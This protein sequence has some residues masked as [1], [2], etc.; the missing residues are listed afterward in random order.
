VGLFRRRT[1]P[2]SPPPPEPPAST[3]WKELPVV[4]RLTGDLEPTVDTR[5]DR[6]LATWQSPAVTRLLDHGVRPDGPSGTVVR[7]AVRPAP[8]VFVPSED[9][10]APARSSTAA[11][12]PA[13]VVSLPGS[14]PQDG[15]E[16]AISPDSKEGMPAIDVER[17]RPVGL[18]A[19][20]DWPTNPSPHALQ[21]AEVIP[22]TV[23]AP[24][25][26][27]LPI[28]GG[29]ASARPVEP[30]AAPAATPGEAE[31]TTEV[32]SE[33]DDAVTTPPS[34]PSPEPFTVQATRPDDAAAPAVS[35]LTS[36]PTPPARLVGLGAPIQ[37][38][39]P[40]PTTPPA[41]T[42]TPPPTT[43]PPPQ[44]TDVTVFHPMGGFPSL[45]PVVTG[46]PAAAPASTSPAAPTTPTAAGLAGPTEPG[47]TARPVQRVS[48]PAATEPTVGLVAAMP[49]IARFPSG[50]GTPVTAG[51]Q[52]GA[53]AVAA[54]SAE[55][56][57]MERARAIPG[58]VR[59]APAAVTPS[60][61]VLAA[62]GLSRTNSV[63]V[64]WTDPGEVAVAA[65]VAQRQLDG[66]VVFRAASADQPDEASVAPTEL[67]T[68]ERTVA[69][70]PPVSAEATAAPAPT[71]SAG[72]TPPAAAPTA[73]LDELA[74]RLYGRLRVMLKH[75]L[76]L[77]RERAGLL[78][79]SRR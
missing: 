15:A 24:P 28:D 60:I 52:R 75:E 35:A 39:T 25:S 49:V 38:T 74:R 69:A 56:A 13:P 19:P 45:Q 18:G 34:T 8:A 9:V 51:V 44:R 31:A 32:V 58:A 46:A 62:A 54:A 40:P 5:F 70:A 47:G 29:T 21:R 23:V 22:P 78:T 26:V 73:D 14:S 59:A 53:P 64:P 33:P 3:A 20:L 30:A 72:P 10:D 76:R 77:D 1:T 7:P 12:A 37:R 17:P 55:P 65:G 41:P 57:R 63:P 11:E 61:G 4:A 36:T 2:A 67:A 68:V 66:S 79:A 71:A 27:T 48:E 43:S 16:T 6:H 42:T 50:A